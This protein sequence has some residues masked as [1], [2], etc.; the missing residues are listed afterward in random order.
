[1]FLVTFLHSSLGPL[2]SVRRLISAHPL[3]ALGF[4]S[5]WGQVSSSQVFPLGQGS[6]PSPSVL[7]RDT[8]EH[9]E[10]TAGLRRAETRVLERECHRA[11]LRTQ[12]LPAQGL[13][14]SWEF[15]S[16]LR[17]FI[18]N[19]FSEE[20]QEN[21]QGCTYLMVLRAGYFGKSLNT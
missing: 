9:F 10:G 4:L 18:R 13:P 20:R 5:V 8:Q 1:M 17:L 6:R 7:L 15:L 19:R 12:P 11:L 21:S 16:L 3:S 14:H 2:P